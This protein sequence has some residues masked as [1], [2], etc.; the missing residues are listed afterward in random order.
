MAHRPPL[1]LRAFQS[2]TGA[3]ACFPDPPQDPRY[4]VTARSAESQ[5]MRRRVV[6]QMQHEL[7]IAAQR[8]FQRIKAVEARAWARLQWYGAEALER[9]QLQSALLLDLGAQHL[10]FGED[11]ARRAIAR[12][13]AERSRALLEDE[14]RARREIRRSEIAA[15]RS[16]RRQRHMVRLQGIIQQLDAE[17]A[18]R[19]PG[20]SELALA[21][22]SQAPCP[23]PLG[24]GPARVR[25]PSPA[26]APLFRLPNASHAH[27]VP[28]AAP[29]T[30][31]QRP[32]RS[33]P[34]GRSATRAPPS[35]G[36]IKRVLPLWTLGGPHAVVQQVSEA[37]GRPHPLGPLPL[38]T[39]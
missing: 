8:Q 12:V 1:P 37:A 38:L 25:G 13:E 36:L 39:S 27:A 26:S 22:P 16:S 34:P 21:A 30:R 19:G 29:L 4:S 33:A 20:A 2:I 10:T 3:G 23:A 35:P 14:D 32:I 24:T 31:A 28:S 5:R 18:A 17:V 7:L 9:V 11:Q 6:R 15:E